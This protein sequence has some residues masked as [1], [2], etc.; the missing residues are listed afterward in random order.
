MTLL[1]FCLFLLWIKVASA[2][3]RV[4]KMF[5]LKSFLSRTFRV[6]RT[7]YKVL[8]RYGIYSRRLFV[9]LFVGVL[10]VIQ[11]NGDGKLACMYIYI[12][13]LIL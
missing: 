10:Y 13:I 3:G 7:R 1:D 5:F 8:K 11:T 9:C 6:G 12:Y 2:L 4:N